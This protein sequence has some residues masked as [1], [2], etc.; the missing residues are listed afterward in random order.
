MSYASKITV[1]DA[2]IDWTQP[3][4]VM[5]R[6]I[7]ACFPAPGAWTTFDGDRFKINSA[8][9]SDSVSAARSAGDHEAVRAGRHRDSSTGTRRG[10]GPGQEA[11]GCRRLGARRR[12]RHRSRGSVPE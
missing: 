8:R 10:S 5:D 3:A 6:L 7:R 11:D 9:I 12:L 1:E 2:R 4:E